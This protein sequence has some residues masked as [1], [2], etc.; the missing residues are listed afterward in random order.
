MLLSGTSL[1]FLLFGSATSQTLSTGSLPPL[2]C[3]VFCSFSR[4]T[5]PQV[6]CD[7]PPVAFRGLDRAAREQLFWAMKAETTARMG[8]DLHR[9]SMWGPP[10]R[11]NTQARQPRRA[12]VLSAE[13][14]MARLGQ[15]QSDG[16]A[17]N[18]V[19]ITHGHSVLCRFALQ[20]HTP[21]TSA[22]A[23]PSQPAQPPPQLS[24]PPPI[25]PRQGVFCCPAR[26][27]PPIPP[28]Q[29]VFM[30][31]ARP[32]PPIPPR[33][34]LFSCPARPSPPIPPRLFLFSRPAQPSFLF[35]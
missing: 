6:L 27:S 2:R 10:P 35:C 32:S 13:E 18:E 23:P 33:L 8:E 16:G 5:L 30:C 24:R 31:P 25:P 21:P 15:S 28:R 19:R 22:P 14:R 4:V 11:Q 1:S 17:S 20:V 3:S 34:F 29:Y 7:D 12:R 9:P 26:P